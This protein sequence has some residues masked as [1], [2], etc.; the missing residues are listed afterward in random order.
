M[1]GPEVAPGRLGLSKQRKPI[2]WE[3]TRNRGRRKRDQATDTPGS[4]LGAFQG[5]VRPP[6]TVKLGGTLFT[7]VLRLSPGFQSCLCWG[8]GICHS[9]RW[10][11]PARIL[12]SNQI[13]LMKGLGDL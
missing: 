8:A 13:M 1:L 5:S 12:G 3:E 6:S 7:S 11:F 2:F 4:L 10:S 9:V